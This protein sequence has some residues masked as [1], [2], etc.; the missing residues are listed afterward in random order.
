MP[1]DERASFFKKIHALPFARAR[2]YATFVRGEDRAAGEHVPC[3]GAIARRAERDFSTDEERCGLWQVLLE[4]ENP[5]PML[6]FIDMYKD[7]KAVMTAVFKAADRIPI[8]LQMALV[9]LPECADLAAR[10]APGMHPAA[11]Q[12]L[13]A[14]PAAR[15]REQ[16]RFAARVAQLRTFDHFIPAP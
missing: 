4:E 10:H 9:S 13:A 15:E 11:Q 3:W 7:N 16:E 2:E 8:P 14:P 5:R 12:L 6:L 1:R